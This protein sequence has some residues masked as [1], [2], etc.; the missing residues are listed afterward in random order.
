MQGANATRARDSALLHIKIEWKSSVAPW[1]RYLLRNIVLA[2]EDPSTPEA[3]DATERVL[4]LIPSLLEMKGRD[5]TEHT[6]AFKRATPYLYHVLM[7]VWFKLL[8]THHPTWGYWSVIVSH[9]APDN[10]LH[11]I[12]LAPYNE[13]PY[14]HNEITGPIIARHLHTPAMQI[15]KMPP[16][17]LTLVENFVGFLP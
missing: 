9:F 8:E 11:R 13:R 17:E 14:I 1:L 16:H 3:L 2:N 15:D 4:V 12:D 6:L 10:L 5:N 7:Q